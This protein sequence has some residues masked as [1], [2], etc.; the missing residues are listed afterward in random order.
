MSRILENV[1]IPKD[2][3]VDEMLVSESTHRPAVLVSCESEDISFDFEVDVVVE[4]A[5]AT[6]LA[7]DE[8]LERPHSVPIRHLGHMHGEHRDEA[9]KEVLRDRLSDAPAVLLLQDLRSRDHIIAVQKLTC[10]NLVKH[11][12]HEGEVASL[13]LVQQEEKSVGCQLPGLHVP[14]VQHLQHQGALNC[15]LSVVTTDAPLVNLYAL[16]CDWVLVPVMLLLFV[17]LAELEKAGEHLIVAQVIDIV[18][19]DQDLIA[20][21]LLEVDVVMNRGGLPFD[22]RTLVHFPNHQA[23]GL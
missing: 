18:Q 22:R 20:A 21:H 19:I 23:N 10:R 12:Q 1:V 15:A 5:L 7:L 14:D 2:R 11:V 6:K 9:L 17:A 8:H 16:R 3:I 13:V 4:E